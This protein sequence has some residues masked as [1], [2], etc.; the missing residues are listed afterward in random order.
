MPSL[1]LRCGTLRSL[2]WFVGCALPLRADSD[3]GRNRRSRFSFSSVARAWGSAC[4]TP[5]TYLGHP[6]GETAVA[7]LQLQPGER[8]AIINDQQ[9][10][11]QLPVR[12][13]RRLCLYDHLVVLRQLLA[14][15]TGGGVSV[16]VA[17]QALELVD[18]A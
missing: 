12:E 18:T 4:E 2:P 14:D 8:P 6:N 16:E 5:A 10:G 11:I 3:R 13:A 15:H 17:D 9:P 7:H 1:T